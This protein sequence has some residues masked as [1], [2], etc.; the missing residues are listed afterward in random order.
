[1][2]PRFSYLMAQQSA[3]CRGKLVLRRVERVAIVMRGTQQIVIPK[4]RSKT[5]CIATENA[6]E[7]Y[8]EE[9]YQV[10]KEVLLMSGIQW[11][12][13]KRRQ[14]PIVDTHNRDSIRN[15]FGSIR[16][17]RVDGRRL[18]GEVAWASDERSQA[19][20]GKWQDGH[21]TDFS[22]T[23]APIE[24]LRVEAGQVWQSIKGPADIITKWQ[25]LDA[26]IVASGAD[27]EAF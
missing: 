3:R 15:V 22:I 11:R 8:D 17:L 6:I 1:M 16:N 18:I 20:A 23:A 27:W 4:N 26:S 13:P 9:R 24:V 5:V 10:V 19:I 2:N 25:P 14:L 7:R 21:L 12:D